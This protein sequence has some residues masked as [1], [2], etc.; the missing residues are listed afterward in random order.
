MIFLGFVRTWSQMDFQE[1]EHSRGPN[2][3]KYKEAARN[4]REER[5]KFKM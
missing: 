5:T 1:K 4:M 3:H 2:F